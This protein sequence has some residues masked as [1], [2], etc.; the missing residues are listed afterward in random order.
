MLVG[1]LF[2]LKY[3]I[4]LQPYLIVAKEQS[5]WIFN[6]DASLNDIFMALTAC[7]LCAII[8]RFY[9]YCFQITDAWLKLMKYYTHFYKFPC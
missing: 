3:E 4:W 7:Q 6:Y 1:F 5:F 8:T 9:S 2:Q